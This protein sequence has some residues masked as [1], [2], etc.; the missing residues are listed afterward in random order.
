MHGD[1]DQGSGGIAKMSRHRVDSQF[2]P[3]RAAPTRAPQPA[4]LSYIPENWSQRLRCCVDTKARALKRLEPFF[5]LWCLSRSCRFVESLRLRML[6]WAGLICTLVT[7]GRHSFR[8]A[9][10]PPAP[11]SVDKFWLG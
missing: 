9:A 6:L 4:D 5:V 10:P 8:G 3:E 2:S 7:Y 11:A 1:V